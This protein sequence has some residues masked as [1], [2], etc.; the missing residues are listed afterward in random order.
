[1]RKLPRPLRAA[2]PALAGLPVMLAVAR[3]RGLFSASPARRLAAL[4][5]GCFVA[6]LPLAG[7][8]LLLLIAQTG[9][10]DIFS[11]AAHSLLV[12][13]TPFRRPE[14]QPDYLTW[15]QLRAERRRQPSRA[16]LCAGMVYLAAAAITLYASGGTL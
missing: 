1:M 3:A 4:S 2:L 8:G 10:F 15:R 12:L 7:F 11:Y 9:F 13:F 6:G 14:D 5:D 16:A